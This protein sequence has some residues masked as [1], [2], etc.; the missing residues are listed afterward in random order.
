MFT[1]KHS[2]PIVQYYKYYTNELNCT[3][4]EN[5]SFAFLLQNKYMRLNH[6]KIKTKKWFIYD[7]NKNIEKILASFSKE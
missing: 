2:N 4:A 3:Q 1:P 6:D 5:G 7:N